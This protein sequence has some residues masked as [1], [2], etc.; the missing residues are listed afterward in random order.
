M[1]LFQLLTFAQ[2]ARAT[3]FDDFEDDLFDY[4]ESH[5]APNIIDLQMTTSAPALA[6]SM[7]SSS[8][9]SVN[10]LDDIGRE[11]VNCCAGLDIQEV[12][13]LSLTCSLD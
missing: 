1:C 5:M 7:G 13:L 9:L 3:G 4:F 12:G 11:I 2:L 6:S 8:A 10:S